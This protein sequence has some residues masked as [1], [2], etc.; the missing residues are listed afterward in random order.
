ML[1]CGGDMGEG[2]GIGERK[3]GGW[4]V[5]GEVKEKVGVWGR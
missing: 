4:E 1:G 3:G 2:V 5:W